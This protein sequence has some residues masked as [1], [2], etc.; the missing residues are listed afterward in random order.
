MSRCFSPQRPF[1]A[2]LVG[3]GAWRRDTGTALHRWHVV[4]RAIVLLWLESHVHQRRHTLLT[5][6]HRHRHDDRHHTHRHPGL[7]R[8]TEHTHWH[9][10]EPIVHAHPHWPDLHH[11]HTMTS[12]SNRQNKSLLLP[13]RGVL[14]LPKHAC[15]RIGVLMSGQVVQ[16]QCTCREL[17]SLVGLDT[18]ILIIFMICCYVWQAKLLRYTTRRNSHQI[19]LMNLRVLL[20]TNEYPEFLWGCRGA[21]GIPVA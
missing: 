16:R 2:P 13:C 21:R 6:A 17:A 5:H 14:G 1:R 11:R 9:E 15:I 19:G 18:F 10:H 7:D 8:S 12:Q 20:L 3:R 4:R